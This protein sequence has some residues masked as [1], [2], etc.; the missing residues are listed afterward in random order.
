M[1]LKRDVT[2]SAT[3]YPAPY[4]GEFFYGFESFPDA[5]KYAAEVNG[6][7]KI[8]QWKDGWSNCIISGAP[9]ESFKPNAN[10]Y[11]DGFYVCDDLDDLKNQ[12][13]GMIDDSMDEEEK[14]AWKESGDQLISL[15][16]SFDWENESVILKDGDFFNSVKKQSMYFHFDNKH[17]VIGVFVSA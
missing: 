10:D 15:V 8:A 11:G 14:A 1:I 2:G 17:D 4:M 6:N 3:G 12:A 7:I 5:V 9:S 13:F 16:A